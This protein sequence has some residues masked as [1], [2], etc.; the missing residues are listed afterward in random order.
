MAERCEKWGNS[1]NI[2]EYKDYGTG[3]FRLLGQH[4]PELRKSS[5]CAGYRHQKTVFTTDL[6][7]LH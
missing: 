3:S 1:G 2:E 4:S 7:L 6:P 5:I